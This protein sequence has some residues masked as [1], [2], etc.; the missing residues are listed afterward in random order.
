MN[1]FRRLFLYWTIVRRLGAL[2][3]AANRKVNYSS[4]GWIYTDYGK[5]YIRVGQVVLPP[6]GLIGRGI[7]LASVEIAER[8]WRRGFFKVALMAVEEQA[9]ANEFSAVV[10]ENV[11]NDDLRPYLT[12]VGYLSREYEP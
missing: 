5:F 12:E 3:D 9:R 1:Y 10:I 4:I 11:L 8:Y 2:I 6:D 7:T